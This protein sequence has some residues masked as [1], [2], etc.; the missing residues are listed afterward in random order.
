ML[1]G[2]AEVLWMMPASSRSK[3]TIFMCPSWTAMY[4]GT[5]PSTA[6][7]LSMSALP[8]TRRGTIS[9]KPRPAAM[10]NGVAPL[11][12]LALSMSALPTSR[13][14]TISICLF[15]TTM[16]NGLSP[17]SEAK[18]KGVQPWPDV[19]L[20]SLVAPASRMSSMVSTCRRWAAWWRG[21]LPYPSFTSG[22]SNSSRAA[23]S[24][25]LDADINIW[26]SSTSGGQNASNA[27][28]SLHIQLSILHHFELHETL[29]STISAEIWGHQSE[30]PG[31]VS[32]PWQFWFH[33]HPQEQ[34]THQTQQSAWS[35]SVAEPGKSKQNHNKRY[36]PSPL[37]LFGQ[38]S[39]RLSDTWNQQSPNAKCTLMGH[40]VGQNGSSQW[41]ALTKMEVLV[42]THP[43]SNTYCFF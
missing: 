19:S 27:T 1:H 21:Y 8:S 2:D 32:L 43:M 38:Q 35:E 17:L 6:L 33:T 4:N 16:C 28:W 31:L 37:H 5:T 14:R 24:L 41:F 25:A 29:P 30:L 12:V 40:K 10:Y 11:S 39:Q 26:P 18:S 36:T 34:A 7:A 23:G 22:W 42:N 9:V 3:H 20:S 15:W 13:R